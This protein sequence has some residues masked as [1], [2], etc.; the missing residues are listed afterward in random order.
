[1]TRPDTQDPSRSPRANA[2]AERFV[3]TARTTPVR[4]RIGI[5]GRT[6]PHLLD[7]PV[8]SKSTVDIRQFGCDPVLARTLLVMPD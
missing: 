3:L 4:R 6:R 7:S 2:Y 1:M 8:N 5:T